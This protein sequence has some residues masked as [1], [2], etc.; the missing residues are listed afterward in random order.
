VEDRPPNIPPPPSEH[1]QPD[2]PSPEDVRAAYDDRTEMIGKGLAALGM[3]YAGLRSFGENAHLFGEM[4][5]VMAN[6][7]EGVREF[8]QEGIRRYKSGGGSTGAQVRAAMY[9]FRW[10]SDREYCRPLRSEFSAR[11]RPERVWEYARFD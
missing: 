8:I 7:I 1:N 2:E 9:G 6:P 3:T 10:G 4:G 5:E 11:S